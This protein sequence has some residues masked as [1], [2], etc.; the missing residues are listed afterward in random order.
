[1]GDSID[2]AVSLLPPQC[3]CLGTIVHRGAHGSTLSAI[4]GRVEGRSVHLS[5]AAF[6]AEWRTWKIGPS[7]YLTDSDLDTL[8][9]MME[10]DDA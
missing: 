5:T 10:T 6:D 8:A 7:I 9:K 3:F 4:V 2:D 1:M